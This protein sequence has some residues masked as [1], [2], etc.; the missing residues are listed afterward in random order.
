MTEKQF[1][2]KL[3][4]MRLKGERNKQIKEI[5]D[6]YAEYV[7]EQKRHRFSSIMVVVIVINIIA[8]VMASFVVQYHTGVEMSPTVTTCFFSFWTVEIV[9]LAGIKI[10][11]VKRNK[12]EGDE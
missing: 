5:E 9:S 6:A 4:K 1:R 10:S 7:P 12:D 2:K 11:K 3:E 8:Y